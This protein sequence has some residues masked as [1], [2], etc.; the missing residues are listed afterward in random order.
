MPQ[1]HEI[2]LKYKNDMNITNDY[3]AE[4]VG[5]NKSTVSRWLK[6][7]TKVMKPEVIE[8]LSYMLGVDVETL[9]K[10]SD[11]YE[12]PILG[13]AKAGY[14]LFVEENFDGY[15]EVSKTDYY[16]GDYF[17]HIKGDSMIGAHIH[18]NDL[19]FVKKCDDV[20][21]GTIAVVL[22]SGEEVTVKRVIKKEELLILEA[23]NPEV[24]S[25]Y[26]TYQEVE[27]LPVKVIGKVLYSR[28]DIT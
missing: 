16:R 20:P 18:N 12:K 10:N 4:A 11:R 22:I 9:L 5:V 19:A 17:L 13:T 6:G 7:E 26:F 8:K 25:R 15:E 24:P 23:A 21:S 14:G 27:E 2:L 3:I 1:F 28:S